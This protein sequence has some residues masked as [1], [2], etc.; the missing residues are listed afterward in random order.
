MANG[1]QPVSR[2][3][4]SFPDTQS[5]IAVSTVASIIILVFVLAFTGKADSDVFKVLTGGLMTVGFAGVM[6]FYFGSSASSKAKDETI[7]TLASN[8]PTKP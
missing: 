7:N 1:D 4:L 8:Q 6:G 3:G 5:I 2:T